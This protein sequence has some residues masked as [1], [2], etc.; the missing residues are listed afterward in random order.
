MPRYDSQP[1]YRQHILHQGARRIRLLHL[2]S[3][4]SRIAQL[5]GYM[6]V[7]S[8]DYPEAAFE[9]L[10]YV[11][12]DASLKESTIIIDGHVL[13][14]AKTLGSALRHLRTRDRPLCIWID[15]ICIN[16]GDED[17]KSDQ[18]A[19]MGDIYR[20]CSHVNVWL[21][22]PTDAAA[23]LGSTASLQALFSHIASNHFHDMPGYFTDEGT[24]QLAFE[25]TDEFTAAWEG[26]QL[27]AES[28]WWTRAWT[29][30]EAI[31][32]PRVHFMYG[33]AEAC[34]FES[35]GKGMDRQWQFGKGLQPCCTEAIALFPRSKV[36]ALW[37][38]FRQYTQISSRRAAGR[39]RDFDGRDCFYMVVRSFADRS[40]LEPRDRIYSLWSQTVSKCYRDH[41]P[42]YSQ[43]LEDVFSEVMK[44]M[45]SE[46]RTNSFLYAGTDFRVLY[47]PGFGPNATK[48]SWVPNFVGAISSES[49]E[50][51]LSRL[52]CSRLFRAAG[53]KKSTLRLSGDELHLDGVYMD[54][55][56]AVGLPVRN[57]DVSTSCKGVFDQWWDM[58]RTIE[59]ASTYHDLARLLCGDVY[60]ERQTRIRRIGRNA[61][62]FLQNAFA[63]HWIK[64]G[65]EIGLHM[66]ANSE[67][68]RRASP[69]DYLRDEFDRLWGG[70]DLDSLEDMA[71]KKTVITALRDRALTGATE[72]EL[73]RS[74]VETS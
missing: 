67:M 36:D 41:T 30:Q 49:V 31:L 45:I 46:A 51:N 11:W 53:W 56:R 10:S 21:P 29:A 22:G 24:G 3:A 52:A 70:G 14:I 63:I 4:A 8:L 54:R 20:R 38:F 55:I 16:Q 71:Y 65:A 32:P 64:L 44:C 18:V 39:A 34:D 7:C 73:R 60:Y 68:W 13:S 5:Q 47:G 74:S 58:I 72:G 33:S 26:F 59:T 17:E 2:Q 9:T 35:I 62:F 66:M 50:S 43:P 28:P 1:L 69:G 48:P 25:E 15:A 27:V 12:G 61:S 37:A 19:L 40:C 42:S 6:S 23:S 57:A